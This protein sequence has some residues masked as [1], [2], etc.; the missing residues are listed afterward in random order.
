MKSKYSYYDNISN[1]ISINQLFAINYLE[2]KD[3]FTCFCHRIHS[4]LP[5][6]D[7]RDID[8]GNV[9]DSATD[10]DKLDTGEGNS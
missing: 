10:E 7:L 4:S 1:I 8:S 5:I 2:I 3:Q 9:D 6:A